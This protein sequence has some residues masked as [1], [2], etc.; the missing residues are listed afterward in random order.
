[1]QGGVDVVLIAQ[2]IVALR[3]QLEEYRVKAAHDLSSFKVG[4]AGVKDSLNACHKR[5]DDFAQLWAQHRG[6]MDSAR[7]EAGEQLKQA[8]KT[9][10]DINDQL[11]AFE[12]ARLVAPDPVALLAP[13]KKALGLLKDDLRALDKSVDLRF[14]ELPG[15][16]RSRPLETRGEGP[17][18]TP[19]GPERKR[20]PE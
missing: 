17:T 20:R 13:V 15:A 18:A 8:G 1:M 19:G 11:K 10:R 3:K 14:E 9:A 5:V 6:E 12:E 4:L 16:R 7:R 2:A